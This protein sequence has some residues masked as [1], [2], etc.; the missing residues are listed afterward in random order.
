MERALG[1]KLGRYEVVHNKD[2]N[3]KNGH[4]DN[5]AVLSL[6]EHSS[7]HMAG[8]KLS[9]STKAKLQK[10]SR[11]KRPVAKLNIEDVR[12]I[13]KML[14]DGIKQRLVGLAFGVSEN[15]VGDINTGQTWSWV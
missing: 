14:S 4:S 5:L 11:L 7:Y 10:Q 1:R 15:A 13:R 3:I 9:N 2:G 6:S 12:D 8:R